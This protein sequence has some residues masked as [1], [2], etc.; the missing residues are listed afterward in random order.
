MRKLLLIAAAP[1]LTGSAF[2]VTPVTPGGD[3]TKATHPGLVL[4][5]TASPQKGEATKSRDTVTA[6]TAAVQKMRSDPHLE[7]LLKQSKGILIVPKF[8]QG[9]A[10]VGGEGGNAVLLAHTGDHWSKPAFYDLGGVSLGAQL[11]GQSGSVALVLMTDK[12]VDAFKERNNFSLNAKAGL[13]VIDYSKAGQANIGRGDVVVWT[14]LQGLYAG[15]TV[16]AADISVDNEA[17]HSFYNNNQMSANDILSGAVSGSRGQDLQQ[18]L[19]G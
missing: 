1:L 10:V 15:A 3:A 18:A 9:G 19:P 17:N 13:T 11:G 5:D 16:G 2:A 4:A 14:D 7:A 6:A 8:V 12:A